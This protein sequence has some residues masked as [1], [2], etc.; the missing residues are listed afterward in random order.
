[1]KIM[2]KIS[3]EGRTVPDNNRFVDLVALSGA[4]STGLQSVSHRRLNADGFWRTCLPGK[5][6]LVHKQERNAVEC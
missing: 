1:M 6:K 2:K 5:C 3:L 4:E